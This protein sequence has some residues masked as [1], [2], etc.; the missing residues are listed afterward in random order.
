LLENQGQFAVLKDHEGMDASYARL[1]G[2]LLTWREAKALKR[3]DDVAGV[4]KLISCPDKRSLLMQYVPARQVVNIEVDEYQS[5]EYFDS[6]VKL[7]N[8]MHDRGIAHGDLRSPTNALIDDSGNAALVDFVA[9]LGQGSQFN[10]INQYL[11]GKLCLVDFSAVTKLKKRIAPQLLN[12]ADIESQDVAGKKG[13]M[14]RKL[15]QHVRSLT[16]LLFTDK[17]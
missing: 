5:E 16:R 15:G 14:F 13:L 6:L 7:I 1:I 10:I 4:P 17:K 9:S 2:P 11:F 8:E 12:E 3:L